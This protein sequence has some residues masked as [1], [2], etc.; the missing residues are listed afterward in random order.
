MQSP[1]SISSELTN[2]S[3][4]NSR[5]KSDWASETHVDESDG[6]SETH[7]RQESNTSADL[8]AEK[9]YSTP[10]AGGISGAEDNDTESPLLGVR[11]SKKGTSGSGSVAT[12]DADSE[13][14]VVGVSARFDV[15]TSE[16]K[17]K[18][19]EVVHDGS[20]DEQGPEPIDGDTL[21]KEAERGLGPRT[22]GVTLKR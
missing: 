21:E 5:A 8:Q 1:R 11:R 14:P 6:A 10:K 9:F 20:G 15:T 7:V 22:C 17:S 3:Q 13:S 2:S 16:L 12:E 4:V 19:V 18:P